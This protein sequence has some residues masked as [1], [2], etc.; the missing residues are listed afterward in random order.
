[1]R[2]ASAWQS[3]ITAWRSPFRF[4]DEQRRGRPRHWASRAPLHQ[5]RWRRAGGNHAPYAV[6]GGYG[7]NDRWINGRLLEWLY[8]SV[9]NKIVLLR[10][11]PEKLRSSKSAM[12]HPYDKLVENGKLV[13][14]KKWLSDA[15]LTAILPHLETAHT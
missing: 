1:M 13:P 10:E 3:G 15:N 12:W 7:W 9:Q 2:R 11:R 4:V 8:L 5:T 6:L 14:I